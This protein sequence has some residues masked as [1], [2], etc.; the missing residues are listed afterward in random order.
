MG[1]WRDPDPLSD[2]L[3]HCVLHLSPQNYACVMASG[4]VYK[5]HD[6]IAFET[7]SLFDLVVQKY[8]RMQAVGNK[9]TADQV[10]EKCE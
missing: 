8:C 5:Y 3:Q 4:V 10:L 9:C 6:R 1:P 2:K 7:T